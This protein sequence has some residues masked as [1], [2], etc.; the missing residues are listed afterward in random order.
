MTID[1]IIEA[2]FGPAPANVDLTESLVLTNDVVAIILLVVAAL[3]VFL[4][5]LVRRLSRAG[6]G[7]DDWAIIV[8][9]I[10]NVGAVGMVA[11]TG[12]YGSG[13]HIWAV[14]STELVMAA[15]I[16]FF[17]TFV[18]GFCLSFNK[19]SILL[20]YRRIFD[21]QVDKNDVFF[22]ISLWTAAVFTVTIPFVLIIVMV[23]ACQPTSHY[24]NQFGGASGT[25][26]VETGT[27]FWTY[28]SINAFMDFLILITPIP[29]IL[30]LQMSKKKRVAVCGMM[31]LGSFVFIVSIIRA[32]KMYKFAHSIDMTWLMGEICVWSSIE[33]SVGIVSACLP[34]L[35]PIFG[36]LRGA[37][38]SK[39]SRNTYIA[40]NSMGSRGNW[41]QKPGSTV[42][43]NHGSVYKRED[44]VQLTNLAD[45]S[46]EDV[47][48]Q[49]IR[50]HC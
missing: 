25:C 10:F 32:V 18:L 41:S 2:A 45:S 26:T 31:L 40:N 8:A 48:Q 47:N 4:R 9:L 3:A 17:Y 21:S 42:A 33:P 29:S 19:L 14:T 13:K 24:W 30:R 12:A 27:F 35:R 39:S 50:E 49:S 20:L 15:K 36:K 38:S 43:K 11:A 28:G 37:V 5:L 6:L 22:G 1:P 23:C 16:L 7:W 46:N 34:N 44:E